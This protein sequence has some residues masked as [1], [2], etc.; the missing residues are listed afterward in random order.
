MLFALLLSLKGD[1]QSGHLEAPLEAIV[2]PS[3]ASPAVNMGT[4]EINVR[5]GTL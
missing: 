1:L 5:S 3:T 4:S 2:M